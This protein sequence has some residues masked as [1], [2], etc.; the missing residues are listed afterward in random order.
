MS[1]FAEGEES[2]E[3]SVGGYDNTPLLLGAME[4][5]H[6]VGLLETVITYMSDIVPRLPQPVR[7][8]RRKSVIDEESQEADRSGSSRSR[9]ASAA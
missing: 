9:T 2:P 3:V 1:L 4:D 5:R 7:D 6:V 8:E